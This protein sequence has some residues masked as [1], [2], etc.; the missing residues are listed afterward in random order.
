MKNNQLKNA[1]LATLILSSF[2]LQSCGPDYPDQPPTNTRHRAPLGQFSEGG[3]EGYAPNEHPCPS[4][5]SDCVVLQQNGTSFTYESMVEQ[6]N[7]F[8][9]YLNNNTLSDYFST[10]SN[11][12]LLFPNLVDNQ[13]STLQS[14][15][16]G[17]YTAAMLNDNTIAIYQNDVLT[18]ENIIFVVFVN[19]NNI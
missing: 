2:V 5:G 19:Y 10:N 7:I 4:V 9:Y 15:I 6:L 11:Y 13:S 3:Y 8:K 16:S 14:L 12:S 1:F 17:T 18:D